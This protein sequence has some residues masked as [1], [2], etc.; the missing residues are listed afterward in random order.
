MSSPYPSLTKV[1]HQKPYP[2][3]DPTQSA[4]STAGKVVLITGGGSGIGSHIAAAFAQSGTTKISILGRTQSKLTAT[5]AALEGKHLGLQVLTFV[6]DITE[7]HVIDKA[8]E[9]TKKAFGPIDIFVANAAYS[10]P[11]QTIKDSN[12]EEWFKGLS[13]NAKGAFITA[14]AFLANCSA[15]PVLIYVAAALSHIPGVP[16]FSGYTVSKVAQLK[17][18]DCLQAE[19][20]HIR[21]MNVHPGICKTDMSV[22]MVG[23]NGFPYDD[24][25]LPGH[26]IV[27]A[28]SEEAAFLKGKFLWSNWDVDELKQRKKEFEGPKLTVG[29]QG[30]P[31]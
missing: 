20:S 6:A 1:Y 22:K 7:P 10:P 31:R 26:F 4:L 5:K 14:Q 27:W 15:S 23:D 30:W 29:L 3:I 8:F 21:V 24:L 11:Y 12:S 28:A 16:T 18:Y 9:R 2:A 13:T 17:F 19:N 25:D